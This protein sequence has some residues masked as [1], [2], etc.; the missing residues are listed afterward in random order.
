MHRIS[1]PNEYLE[2]TNN[3]Y[4]L[5]GEETALI[6]AG[7]DTPEVRDAVVDGFAAAGLTIPDLDRIFLTHYHIDHCGAVGWLVDQ[8]GASV[9]AH[10]ADRPLIEGNETA[11]E[12]LNRQRCE[13]LDSWGVPANKVEA[14][15]DAFVE[16]PNLYADVSVEPIEDN[17]RVDCC[18]TPLRTHHTPGHSLGHLA[19]VL[20]ARDEVISGDALLPVYTPNIGGADIRVEEPLVDYLETLQWF[21]DEKFGRAWPGHRTTIADPAGRARGIFHHHE[22]RAMRVLR[23]LERDNL[24]TPWAVSQELFGSLE[25]VHIL[26]GPGEAY[27]HL[28]HLTRTG[29]LRRE[30][31]GYRLTAD[32]A[33]RVRS[34]GEESW[35]LETRHRD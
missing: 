28:N 13:Q 11:W 6:D 25:G 33:E 34:S 2:G 15:F 4:L 31:E 8:S 23:T 21:V 14:L 5:D 1:L 3:V 29:A 10:P 27:A 16:D 30:K 20:P 32:T 35:E 18:G 24:M 22:E 17:V 7:S 9:H 12:R 19:F 26:H